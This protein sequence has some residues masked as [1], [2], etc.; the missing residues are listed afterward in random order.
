MM[1]RSAL[2]PRVNPSLGQILCVTGVTSSALLDKEVLMEDMTL[3]ELS[4]NTASWD[5]YVPSLW[6]TQSPHMT[7]SS[8]WISCKPW[9]LTFAIHPKRSCGANCKCLSSH[10]TTF[11]TTCSKQLCKIRWSVHSMNMMLMKSLATNLKLLNP[12]VYLTEAGTGTT[13]N[14][15][16]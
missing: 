6:I 9:E 16:S 8:A 11:P 12:S 13:I 1:K 7:L 15:V 4:S 2:P 14:A 10:T 3:P 5:Q